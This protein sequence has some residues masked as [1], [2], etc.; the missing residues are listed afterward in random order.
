MR[1]VFCSVGSNMEVSPV[2]IGALTRQHFSPRKI[3]D[4]WA[5]CLDYLES[6]DANISQESVPP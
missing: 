4:N 2:P 3:C 6:N 1:V 5:I